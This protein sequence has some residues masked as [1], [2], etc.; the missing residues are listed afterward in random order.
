M[1]SHIEMLSVA[2]IEAHVHVHVCRYWTTEIVKHLE[3]TMAAEE[4]K[5]LALK[6]TMRTI[7][8]SFTEQWVM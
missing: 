4:E 1:V 8:H 7:F 2:E 3:V 5:Q 6:D